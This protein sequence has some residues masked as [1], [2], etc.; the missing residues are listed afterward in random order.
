MSFWR[1]YRFF[2]VVS[3]SLS[4]NYASYVGWHYLGSQGSLELFDVSTLTCSR[5]IR[6]VPLELYSGS[7]YTIDFGHIH[8]SS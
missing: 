6:G 7:R 4:L 8:L 5:N 1:P 2:E 3:G